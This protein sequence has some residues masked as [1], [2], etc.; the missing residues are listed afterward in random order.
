[1]HDLNPIHQNILELRTSLATVALFCQKI[2]QHLE[3]NQSIA[4]SKAGI[5]R[6]FNPLKP[7]KGCVTVEFMNAEELTTL[8]GHNIEKFLDQS[9]CS[10][11]IIE[12][13]AYYALE[14]VTKSLKE[15]L[16]SL[17]KA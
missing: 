13:E 8:L 10:V 9:R 15:Y 16:S 3:K 5:T 2:E 12:R 7:S 11:R 17:W 4:P 6:A 14:D 1:M